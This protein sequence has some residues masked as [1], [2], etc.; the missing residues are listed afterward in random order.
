MKTYIQLLCNF[1]AT[2]LSEVLLFTEAS[3]VSAVAWVP[4]YL[5][6]GCWCQHHY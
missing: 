2:S 3:L 5:N 4:F 6:V 1:V